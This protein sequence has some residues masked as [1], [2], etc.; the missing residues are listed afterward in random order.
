MYLIE[1]VHTE[2]SEFDSKES[3]KHIFSKNYDEHCC[4]DIDRIF[5]EV[6]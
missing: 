6:L 5:W 2:V 1:Q 4:D 3:D